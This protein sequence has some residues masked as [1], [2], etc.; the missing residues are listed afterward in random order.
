MVAVEKRDVERVAALARLEFSDEE[1]VSFTGE[2]NRILELFVQMSEVDTDG[3][4]PAFRELLRKNVFRVDDPGEMLDARE[5]LANA[6]DTHEGSFRVPAV[7]PD[8]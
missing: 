2:M 3:V 4:E 5:A 8:D 1:L 6:P 7:I